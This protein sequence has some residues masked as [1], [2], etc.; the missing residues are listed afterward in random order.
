ML[1]ETPYW[2]DNA[3][4][5]PNLVIR[6]LPDQA[7]VVIVGSGYTGLS[8]ARVLALRGVD[9]VVLEKET[10]GWGASSRNGGQVLT[11]LKLGPSALIKQVGLTRAKE[12]H[13]LSLASIQYL[14][15]L[16][17]EENIGCEYTRP[18]HIEAAWKNSHFAHYRR[19]QEVLARE[20]NHPVTLIDREAQSCELGTTYYRGLLIDERSGALHPARFVRGLAICASGSGALLFEKTPATKIMR[21]GTG[22]AVVTPQGT[23]R[24]ENILIATNGY[25]DNAAR[26]IC[27][28][29][30][31]LGS[32]IVATEPLPA[33]V[34]E[35]LIPR[36]RV[37]FDSKRYLYYFRLSA[38]NR[39]LF[40]GR[41]DYRPPTPHSTRKSAEILRR[42]MVQI[43]PELK[44]VKIEYAWSG[45]ISLTRDSFPRAGQ[46]EGLYYALGYGGHGVAMATY[47]GGQLANIMCGAPGKNPFQDLPFDPLPFYYGKPFLPLGALYYKLLDVIR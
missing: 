5:L 12:L 34:A 33:D 32:Y 14:E 13:A 45:N 10:F 35:K 11:G 22:Y 46:F 38:D 31:S 44:D 26:E 15:D 47:L 20:F 16:I 19:E 30:F 27:Q 3:P 29:V 39:L 24:V 9:V 28:R 40:G 25:T 1:K 23:I 42:G 43:F 36:R 7:D 2:W 8:A 37:V 6:S 18:G 21:A 41:A 4:V 17:A